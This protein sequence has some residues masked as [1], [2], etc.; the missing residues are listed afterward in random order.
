MKKLVVLLFIAC[1]TMGFAQQPERVQDN[2]SI[3]AEPLNPLTYGLRDAKDGKEE[4]KTYFR[5]L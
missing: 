2:S 3:D 4:K 5:H 1:C